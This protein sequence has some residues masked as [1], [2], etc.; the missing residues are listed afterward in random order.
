MQQAVSLA[1][2]T[3]MALYRAVTTT[4]MLPPP[5]WEPPLPPRLMV[6]A[7]LW[8]AS[9]MVLLLATHTPSTAVTTTAISQR[10]LL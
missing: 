7:V 10:H 9:A 3:I 8:D 5:M 4:V 2:V 6:P 1:T